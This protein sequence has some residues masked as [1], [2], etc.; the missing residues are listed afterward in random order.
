MAFYIR[1]EDTQTPENGVAYFG[2]FAE[3]EMTERL[4]DA[5]GDLLAGCGDLDEEILTDE[6]AAGIY[7]NPR[8]YWMDQLADVERQQ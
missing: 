2:P 8:Q 1:H 4:N 7:I 6:E 5:Y 3:D